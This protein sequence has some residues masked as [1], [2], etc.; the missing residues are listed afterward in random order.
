MTAVN[1]NAL[2]SVQQ[3]VQPAS[4]TP[5]KAADTAKTDFAKVMNGKVSERG[6]NARVNPEDGVK[7]N[8]PT[9]RKEIT[10]SD[11]TKA[12]S[13]QE[14]KPVSKKEQLAPETANEMMAG[15]AQVLNITPEELKQALD[16]LGLELGDLTDRNNVAQLILMLNGSGD[17][18]DMLIDNGMLETFNEL[19]DFIAETLETSGMSAEEFKNALEVF[20]KNNGNE[21]TEVKPELSERVEAEKPID[22]DGEVSNEAA[23]GQTEEAITFEVTRSG[24]EGSSTGFSDR[25]SKGTEQDVH[26]VT[27]AV[28]GFVRNLEMTVEQTGEV[29]EEQQVSIRDIVYQ[30]VQR[31]RVNISPENTSLEMRLNPE[32]LGR[33]SINITSNNGVMTARIDT[34][35]QKAREAIES[36]LQILKENI[37]AKGIKVEAVEVRISDFN[38]AN[39]T[40][41]GNNEQSANGEENRGS[42]RNRQVF[43]QGTEDEITEAQR[44]AREVLADTGSTVSYRA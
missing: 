14:K 37:E 29:V 23:I 3:I 38:M 4:V 33:V 43:E 15:A 44:I 16:A 40:E 26:T 2:G 22:V 25:S 5:V 8:T 10:N 12:F 39:N 20:G 27:G 35:N 18:S 13:K 17:I 31:I 41:T 11:R 19:N 34:E 1:L 7:T 28:E 24:E 42:R 30:V 36:Q 6:A 21:V 9:T 32:N